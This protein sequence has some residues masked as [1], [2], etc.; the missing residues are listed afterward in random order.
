WKLDRVIASAN[1]Q[2]A[3]ADRVNSVRF[4]PDGQFLA[5]GSGEPSRS[6]EVKIWRVRDGDLVQELKGLHSDAVLALAY[7]PDGRYLASGGADRFAKI[8]EIAT[9]KLVRV[10]EGHTHHVLSLAWKA[11][12]HTLLTAGADNLVK[13]WDALSGEKRKGPEAFS[14]EVT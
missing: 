11:D 10:L 4:S 12:G 3:F 6:G 2:P 8:T 13:V 9:G 14:K 1:G 7:S 5:T